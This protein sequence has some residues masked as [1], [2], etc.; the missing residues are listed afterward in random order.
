M[1]G[2]FA[3]KVVDRCRYAEVAVAE[4]ALDD[5][6]ERHFAGR[7]APVTCPLCLETACGSGRRRPDRCQVLEFVDRSGH[8]L[9]ALLLPCV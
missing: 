1:D 3:G 9:L 8:A 6:D 7:A 4:L 5:V 2:R